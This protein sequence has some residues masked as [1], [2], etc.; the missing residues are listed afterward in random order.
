[1]YF[2]KTFFDNRPIIIGE[3]EP[4][5]QMDHR[6]LV[7]T[8]RA[9]IGRATLLNAII[10][11]TVNLKQPTIT[12]PLIR[13]LLK[14][15]EF[16]HSIY[17]PVL[18]KYLKIDTNE[19]MEPEDLNME[20]YRIEVMS[21]L[22]EDDSEFSSYAERTDIPFPLR[23]KT[24]VERIGLVLR[25]I[26]GKKYSQ[27]KQQK[28]ELNREDRFSYNAPRGNYGSTRLYYQTVF[29][30][31]R[32]MGVTKHERWIPLVETEEERHP[33]EDYNTLML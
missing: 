10:P 31:Q 5:A 24:M 3:Y 4:E 20:A 16:K 30:P 2:S 33:G 19:L 11:K 21:Q 29:S 13:S 6:Y 14:P 28:I 18:K 8:K 23:R 26:I 9:S 17:D 15:D 12:S 25:G 1:M 22:A 27:L 32:N 7:R